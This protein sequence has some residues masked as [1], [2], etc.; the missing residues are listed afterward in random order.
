VLDESAYI[1]FGNIPAF[2]ADKKGSIPFM[3]ISINSII[4]V[5]IIPTLH[6][7]NNESYFTTFNK[8]Y[9]PPLNIIISTP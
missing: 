7:V 2:Q 5:P 8:P 4:I 3:R 1:I 9:P 6:Y